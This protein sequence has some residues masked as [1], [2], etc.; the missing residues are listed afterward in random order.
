M[1]KISCEGRVYDPADPLNDKSLSKV[2]SQ[3]STQKKF[4]KQRVKAY[5]IH[6]F[7]NSK[8]RCDHQ[9]QIAFLKSALK[10]MLIKKEK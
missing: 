9:K 1:E 7:Y 2:I 6:Y 8:T 4:M 10:S 5:L 3:K